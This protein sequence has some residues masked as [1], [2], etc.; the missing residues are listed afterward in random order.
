M[1]AMRSLTERAKAAYYAD[2]E[3]C[4]PQQ[5]Q[6]RAIREAQVMT[7]KLRAILQVG[8]DDDAV[9]DVEPHSNTVAV[10]GHEFEFEGLAPLHK[11]YLVT[12]C[13]GCSTGE[14]RHHVMTLADI[15]RALVDPMPCPDCRAASV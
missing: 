4:R 12:P 2:L 14:T 13:V 8:A 6:E 10:E 5:G 15:G 3:R 1:I 7:A 9:P 11:V